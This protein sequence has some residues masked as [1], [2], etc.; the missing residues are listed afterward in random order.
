MADPTINAGSIS[1][2]QM[3]A[4]V[5]EIYAEYDKR[6]KEYEAL[7]T[8]KEDLEELKQLEEKIKKHDK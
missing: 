6:R 8:D 3:E 1:A 2:K 7:E 5:R 4:K